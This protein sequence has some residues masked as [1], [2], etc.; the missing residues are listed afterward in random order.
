MLSDLHY[1]TNMMT[2]FQTA[3]LCLTQ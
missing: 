3:S 1:T 2:G